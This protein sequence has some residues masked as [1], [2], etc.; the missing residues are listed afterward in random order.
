MFVTI[1]TPSR[2]IV[3]L[4]RAEEWAAFEASGHFAGSPDDRRDGYIHISTPEQV[5][6]TAAKYFAGTAGVVAVTLDAGA[7]G[8][9][10]RWEASRGGMLF[11]HLYRPL[12]LGDVVSA[13]PF[14]GPSPP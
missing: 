5:A 12:L 4:L 3:K 8:E 7:L 13:A 9:A 14:A 1:Q 11:P 6:G 2:P 10:L